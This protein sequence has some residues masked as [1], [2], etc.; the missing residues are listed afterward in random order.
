MKSLFVRIF[1]SFWLAMGLILTGSVGVTAAFIIKRSTE[2]QSLVP[3]ELAVTAEQRL[4]AGGLDGL[5]DWARDIRNTYPGLDVFIVDALGQSVTRQTPP[6]FIQRRISRLQREGLLNGPSRRTSSPGGDLLRTEPQITAANGAVYTLVFSQVPDWSPAVL[7]TP[8]IQILLLLLAIAVSGSICWYL[9][10]SVTR[11]VEKLQAGARSLANGNLDARVGAEFSGRKDE[12]AVLAHDFDQM[13]DRLRSLIDSK[14]VLMRDVSHELRTP[15]ARLRL[16]L[17]LARREGADLEREHD[18]IEREAE[19][20]D[21][22]IG[23]ILRLARLN[24][25]HQNV[26]REEFDYA[27][28]ISAV[29]EDA[30]IEASA[31]GKL[32]SFGYSGALQIQG[33]QELL[34]SA[35]ENVVRNALRFTAV[36]TAVEISLRSEGQMALLEVRDHGPGVPEAELQR[37]FEP[38]YR[39]T[40]QAR[41]RD[42]GGYGLGL[43]ITARVM[44]VHHGKVEARN[45]A[46]GGLLLTLNVP[47]K[48]P[49]AAMG[50]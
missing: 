48:S 1:L 45:A 43:A 40:M 15:L 22:L 28:L 23:E 33:D 14:E 31:Q 44:N 37:L 7:G 27:G 19:R 13:A 41:E 3:G 30:R 8:D 9:T 12:L 36:N 24:S 29:A 20:L 21:E 38:F 17:G 26:N 49:T 42:T 18:R 4:V 34:R 32:V 10:R 11:P 47:L 16:A 50:D 2:I 35:I 46:D 25:A 39:V 5:R 6:E